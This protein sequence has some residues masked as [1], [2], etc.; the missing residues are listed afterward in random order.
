MSLLHPSGRLGYVWP[1]Y[2]KSFG[3]TVKPVLTATSEQQPPAIKT[4]L[5]PAQPKLVLQ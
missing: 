3:N 4:S 2:R 5:N 1:I